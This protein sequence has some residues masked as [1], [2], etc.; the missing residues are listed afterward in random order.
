MRPPRVLL[1][2]SQAIANDEEKATKTTAAAV[3]A[4]AAVA[5]RL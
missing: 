4:V 5:A 1:A 2:F 3:V